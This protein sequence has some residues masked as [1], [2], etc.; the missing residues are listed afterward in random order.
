LS[1]QT[2]LRVDICRDADGLATLAPTWRALLS[3]VG[4]YSAA[5]T[6][7]Y[8]STAWN[9][10]PRDGREELAVI[11]IWRGDDLACVWPLQIKREGALRSATHLGAGDNGE[12]A[13]PVI[14]DPEAEAVARLALEEAKGLA[15]TLGVFALDVNSPMTRAI[16]SGGGIRYSNPL[17][18]PVVAL[19]AHQD[20]ESW[21]A[22]K[23]GNFR[24]Q[25]RADRRRLAAMGALESVR[26]IGPVD[27]PAL[28]DWLFATKAEWLAERKVTESWVF[29][30][31][32]RALFSALLSEP[33]AGDPD[34]RTFQALA[35]RLDGKII[36]GC[37][38][39]K[40]TDMIEYIMPGF[41]PAYGAHSPGALL[42]EDC[43]R[44]ASRVGLDFDFRI[45]RDPYKL[46]WADKDVR[47]AT[48]I[49]A[50]TPKAAP[51]VLQLEVNRMVRNVRMTLGPMV[52][53]WR[54]PRKAKS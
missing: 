13:G 37:V 47:Y 27:G 44:W 11:T 25:L 20:F 22:T 6:H 9:C 32:A 48:H 16:E 34:Q 29:Q 53:R 39:F 28:V 33:D 52:K 38:C 46:R 54:K 10:L 18:S 50:C 21:F 30:P 23:S 49:I 8:V 17:V 14:G 19:S 15:D 3:R 41:D 40:S 24:Q 31:Q 5:Q 2:S 35:L 1:S 43:A 4:R 45:T 51:R 7:D 42:I 26:M 36:A 12:Y